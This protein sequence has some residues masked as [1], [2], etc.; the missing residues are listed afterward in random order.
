MKIAIVLVCAAL[1]GWVGGDQWEDS[2]ATTFNVEMH[3]RIKAF[4]TFTKSS[5]VG[6][7]SLAIDEDF[8][9]LFAQDDA[10]FDTDVYH[11]I[12]A[13]DAFPSVSYN[14][15]DGSVIDFYGNTIA[16]ARIKRILIANTGT[17][18][19]QTMNVAGNLMADMGSGATFGG[20][21]RHL[22]EDPRDGRLVTATTKDTLTLTGSVSGIPYVISIAGLAQ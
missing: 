21:G 7:G 20:N 22:Y 1:L 13:A 16:M 4:G 10:D 18:A 17:A 8:A 11:K 9:N 15:E 5:D 3:S 12:V 6:E 19:A 2:M 14:L